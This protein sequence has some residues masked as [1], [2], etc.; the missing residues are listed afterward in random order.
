[1]TLSL[2]LSS[3]AELGKLSRRYGG[4]YNFAFPENAPSQRVRETQ[5]RGASVGLA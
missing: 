4:S 5:K 2:P 1:M 3:A